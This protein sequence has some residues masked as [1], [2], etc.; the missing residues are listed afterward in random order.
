MMRPLLGLGLKLLAP[1]RVATTRSR[2]H[3]TA[4]RGGR[5][6]ELRAPPARPMRQLIDD[7]YYHNVI[8][9]EI[10]GFIDDVALA[11]VQD[12]ARQHPQRPHRPIPR[13]L[14]PRIARSANSTRG[15]H[16]GQDPTENE[17]STN[18]DCVATSF[19]PAFLCVPERSCAFV[20]A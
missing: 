13:R 10:E 20:G 18:Y 1:E 12:R 11:V 7:A 16:H 2:W 3:V 19:T 5:V 9:P 15:P 8:P 6:I 4:K 17:E 14:R